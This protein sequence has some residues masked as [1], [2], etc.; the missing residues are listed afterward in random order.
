M[1]HLP[2]PARWPRV[3]LNGI[4][5]SPVA[6]VTKGSTFRRDA[7]AEQVGGEA[8]RALLSTTR[9]CTQKVRRTL[10]TLARMMSI[11]P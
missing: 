9:V 2:Q 11:V 10:L 7:P 8:L 1:V 6:P 4:D 3:R 5:R